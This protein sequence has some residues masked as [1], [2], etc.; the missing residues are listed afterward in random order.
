MHSDCLSKDSLDH[1][2]NCKEKMNL[3]KDI[4]KASESLMMGMDVA[5]CS[6]KISKCSSKV[7]TV[8][9]KDWVEFKLI[10]LGRYRS[11]PSSVQASP[12]PPDATTGH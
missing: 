12:G 2:P 4:S 7:N 6:N 8:T 5:R 1:C 9:R 10:S 3:I 11:S